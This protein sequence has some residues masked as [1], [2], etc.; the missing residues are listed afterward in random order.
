MIQLPIWALPVVFALAYIAFRW[1]H[2]RKIDDAKAAF[3]ST[4]KEPLIY[5]SQDIDDD[6]VLA[7]VENARAKLAKHGNPF[8]TANDVYFF[9]Y[10]SDGENATWDFE[11]WRDMRMQW[12]IDTRRAFREMKA[13]QMAESQNGF[14]AGQMFSG[15][16]N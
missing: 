3:W 11:A 6:Q 10:G 2:N 5:L 8:L 7:R 14:A 12:A 1:L 15:Q 4:V 16:R 9:V 13:R